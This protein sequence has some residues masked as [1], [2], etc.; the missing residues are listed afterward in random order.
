MEPIYR[1]VTSL[2]WITIVILISLI[3]LVIAKRAFAI[4]FSNFI[5]LPFNSKY[6]FLYNKKDRLN[7]GFHLFL[8]SFQILNVSLYIFWILNLYQGTDSSP[9]P[10][11]FLMILGIVVI[12]FLIKIILQLGNALVFYNYRII[13]EFIFKKIS[14][15]NYSSGIMMIANVIFTYINPQAMTVFYVS[16]VLIV[17]VNIVGWVNL[18][19]SRQKFIL[20]YFFYF[21]LYL[22]ALEIS[23][24]VII[25]HYLNA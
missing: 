1:T 21:I 24:F 2:D 16:F 22:C 20:S 4:R 6:V 8:T 19:K 25:A 17:L 5:I 10:L 7:H 18:I 23:P 3:I 12:F 13:S 9:S 15:L 14:Y 11:Y